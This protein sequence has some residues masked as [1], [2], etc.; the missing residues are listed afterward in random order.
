MIA[1]Q[2]RSQS[3]NLLLTEEHDSGQTKLEV[4]GKEELTPWRPTAGSLEAGDLRQA[5]DARQRVE[6]SV[7]RATL[8]TAASLTVMRSSREG[9][10]QSALLTPWMTVQVLRTGR[11]G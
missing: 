9:E 11:R 8:A 7:K 10:V 6:V 4:G 5:S 3:P 2:V 1:T